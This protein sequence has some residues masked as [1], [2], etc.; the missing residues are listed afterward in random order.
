MISE[1]IEFSLTFEGADTDFHVID[2]YDVTRAMMGFQR[3]LALTTHLVLTGEI[4]TQATAFSGGRIITLPFEEGSWKTRA[5]IIGYAGAALYALG[6][7]PKDSPVGNLVRTAY[8]YVISESLG[9]HVDYDKSLLQQYEEIKKSKKDIPPLTQS[10]LDSLAEKCEAAL[11]DIHRPIVESG[12]AKKATISSEIIGLSVPVG[13]PFTPDTYE[14]IN[15]TERLEDSER[16][17]GRVS[18]YNANTFKGRIYM[19]IEKR[20]IPFLLAPEARSNSLINKITR[21]LS[22]SAV[23]R[24]NEDANINVYAYKNISST[25]RLKSIYVISEG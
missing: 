22:L 18:S 4:I 13:V 16:I 9:F 5:K 12:T 7:A 19:G 2:M 21:S 25:G 11:K 15:F 1:P 6:V 23:D 20:P 17:T 8:D 24:F 3:S 10:K 14:Y